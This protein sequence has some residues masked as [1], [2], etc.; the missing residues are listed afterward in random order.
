MT[1]HCIKRMLG[2]AI[3]TSMAVL[4]IGNGAALAQETCA[5]VAIPTANQS[6]TGFAGWMPTALAEECRTRV[7]GGNQAKGCFRMDGSD[8]LTDVIRNAI[9]HSFDKD[10]HQGACVNYHNVGSGAGETNMYATIDHTVTAPVYQGLAG[11]SRNFANTIIQTRA[12]WQPTSANVAALDAGLVC[13]KPTSGQLIN[14]DHD[15]PHKLG[16]CT[17]VCSKV[18]TTPNF[19]NS[20]DDW[21]LGKLYP[22]SPNVLTAMGVILGGYPAADTPPIKATT[23]ECSDPCRIC[24]LNTLASQHGTMGYVEHILRRDDKSG[25]QDTFRERFNFKQWCN[26]KSEGNSNLAG[27][28]TK[29]DDLD[30]IRRTCMGTQGGIHAVTSCSYYPTT[31]ACAPG[32]GDLAAG[33]TGNTL[34]VP[35]KCTQGVVVAMSENDPDVDVN[36]NPLDITKS[37]GARVAT[38]GAGRV[39]GLAGLASFDPKATPNDCV[40]IESTTWNFFPND[41]N[42]AY[43]ISRRLFIQRNPD[44]TDAQ[45]ISSEGA[46]RKAQEDLLWNWIQNNECDSAGV[47]GDESIVKA[48]GFLPKWQQG[49]ATGCLQN[50]ATLTCLAADPG[51]GAPKM[52]VG[53]GQACSGSYH[54]MDTFTCPATCPGFALNSQPTGDSCLVAP[55][56]PAAHSCVVDSSGVGGVCN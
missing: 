44:F 16:F 36:N 6:Q 40:N 38:D 1:F 49:C 37:I 47:T 5:D 7:G 26:G 52:N 4:A 30:P 9:I 56:C 43:P 33:A 22:E 13:F 10:I 17:D 39:I 42:G 21:G 31:I 28:N 34:G 27:S 20:P 24:L 18:G 19:H 45:R 25:T 35:I 29:N 23:A 46:G 41:Y 53:Y 12:N 48:A 8:T 15:M 3:P 2:V 11:M 50:G 51:A 55:M 54:C 32:A 14:I